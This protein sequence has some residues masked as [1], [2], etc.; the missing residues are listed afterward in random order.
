MYIHNRKAFTCYMVVRSKI[1]SSF[2]GKKWE[3]DISNENVSP[4]LL[5]KK[6]LSTFREMRRDGRPR[7]LP[8]EYLFAVRKSLKVIQFIYFYVFILSY[9]VI[10]YSMTKLF[11]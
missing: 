11:I 4:S 8:S 1:E 10:G 9:Y 7:K 5:E 3:G 6:N 2:F